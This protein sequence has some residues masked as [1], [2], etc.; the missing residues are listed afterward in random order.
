MQQLLDPSNELNS[1]DNSE[2]KL[3]IVKEFTKD[4]QNYLAEKKF[5]SKNSSQII[6]LRLSKISRNDSA[7]TKIYTPFKELEVS[8]EN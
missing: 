1:K 4:N 8:H 6:W 7:Q 3:I 5:A 2:N